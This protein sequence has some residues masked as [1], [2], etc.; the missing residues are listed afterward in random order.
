MSKFIL[1]YKG[2]AVEFTPEMNEA[3]GVAWGKWVEKLGS[4]LLDEGA[5]FGQGGVVTEKGAGGVPT[6]LT[7]YTIISADNLASAQSLAM[8]NPFIVGSSE[9]SLEVFELM[10]M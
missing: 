6:S 9:T 3:W 8:G 2:P 1:L 7:G 10:A 5:P 4:A